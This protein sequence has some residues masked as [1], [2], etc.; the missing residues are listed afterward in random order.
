MA[1]RN[2][3]TGSTTFN[4]GAQ[5]CFFVATAGTA[6]SQHHISILGAGTSSAIDG[7]TST[8]PTTSATTV[9]T[10]DTT[11]AT[12]TTI[13]ASSTVPAPTTTTAIPQAG[14]LCDLLGALPGALRRALGGFLDG[15]MDLFNCPPAP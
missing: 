13:P 6:A 8:S 10:S 9:P 14:L 12:A 11:V 1:R 5:Q 7:P 3:N 2:I 4:C 15:L